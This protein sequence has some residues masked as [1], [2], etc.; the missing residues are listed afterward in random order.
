[1]RAAADSGADLLKSGGQG[2]SN[3]YIRISRIDFRISTP[4]IHLHNRLCMH[5]GIIL[6][7]ATYAYTGLPTYTIGR[8]IYKKPP[9]FR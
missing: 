9:T 1:M 5:S 6:R 2:P 8:L 3:V 7:L 4:S